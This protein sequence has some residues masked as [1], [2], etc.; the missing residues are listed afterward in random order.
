M[1][2]NLNRVEAK[3][4]TYFPIQDAIDEFWHMNETTVESCASG[5]ATCHIEPILFILTSPRHLIKF[6]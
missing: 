1:L 4:L 5:N 3:I 6:C 2:L